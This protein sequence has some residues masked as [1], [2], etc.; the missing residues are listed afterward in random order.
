M[1]IYKCNACGNIV[2]ML[3]DSGVVPSCC[4]EEMEL[5]AAGTSD[6]AVE[7]HVPVIEIK[8]SHVKVRVG[9]Y[10][11]PMLSEHYIM[12]I[13]LVTD[14]GFH[15]TYLSPTDEPA[16]CFELCTGETPTEA[17]AYCNLHGLWSKTV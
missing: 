2:T 11:H 16:A 4:G 1:K 10:A 6:G 5:L 7:K 3:E 12:W 15:I 8:G 13:L 17:Y 9:E 14:K